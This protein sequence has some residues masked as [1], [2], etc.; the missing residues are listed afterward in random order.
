MVDIHHHLLPGLDDGAP[1]METSVAMAKMA[2]ADG[3]T[4]IS[5]SPHANGKYSYDLARNED[6][7]NTLRGRLAR[8]GVALTLGIGCDFHLSYDN[9]Q[10]CACGYEEVHHQRDGVPAGGVAGLRASARV[11]GDVLPD[12]ACGDDADPHASGE[13]P[14]AAVGDGPGCR[15]AAW[16][17]AGAGDDQLDYGWDGK[18]GGAGGA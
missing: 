15:L 10:A 6:L 9:V 4:H 11:D 17:A 5:C 3:I 14:D 18:E 8:D 13:E 1:D 12:T 2:V 7:A 16:R